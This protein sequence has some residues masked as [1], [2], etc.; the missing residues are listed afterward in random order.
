[1]LEKL[2]LNPRFVTGY[3]KRPYYPHSSPL[4]L[5]SAGAILVFETYSKAYDTRKKA[6]F[7]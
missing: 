1:M 5:Y 6:H 2:S 3:G 4:L 7:V